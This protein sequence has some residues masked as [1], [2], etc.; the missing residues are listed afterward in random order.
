V[1]WIKKIRWNRKPVK[2]VCVV[3]VVVLYTARW[4]FLNK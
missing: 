2:E 4:D 3:G 1:C